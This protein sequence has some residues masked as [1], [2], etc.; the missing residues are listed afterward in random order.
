MKSVVQNEALI[1]NLNSRYATKLFDRTRSISES[2]WA[3]LSEALRLSP[4]SYGLQPWKF[5]VVQNPE[6]RQKLRV[7]SWGQAQVEDC[8]HFVVF[9]TLRNVDE[10]YVQKFIDSTARARNI[11]SES[12]KG[13]H[14]MMVSRIANNTSFNHLEWTRRQSYIAMGFLG[15]SAALLGIDT[16]MLE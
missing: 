14:D 4:S 1:E 11:S 5:I 8:S 16:C 3:T 2:D 10:A 6:I 7:A 13:Y 12:L 9:T 15:L